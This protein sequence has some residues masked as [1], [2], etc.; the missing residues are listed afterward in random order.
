MVV[1]DWDRYALC[2]CD[3][4]SYC[5]AQVHVLGLFTHKHVCMLCIYTC[6]VTYI[7]IGI[8]ISHKKCVLNHGR[9]PGSCQ[10]DVQTEQLSTGLYICLFIGV[11]VYAK[12]SVYVYL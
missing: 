7:H 8:F 9:L 5:I 10:S 6:I 4:L 2:V 3:M 1:N 11:Y 12:E